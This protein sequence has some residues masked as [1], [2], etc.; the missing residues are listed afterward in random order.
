[1]VLGWPTFNEEDEIGARHADLVAFDAVGSGSKTGGTVNSIDELGRMP[2]AVSKRSFFGRS[3][4]CEDRVS[5]AQCT[6]VQR[7]GAGGP[8]Y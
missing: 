4:A 6:V 1:M 2:L 3:R 8:G 7:E 5:V